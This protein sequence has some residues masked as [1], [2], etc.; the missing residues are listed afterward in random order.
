MNSLLTKVRGLA[1]DSAN[2]GV[3][4]ASALAANQAEITNSIAT[5]NNIANTTKFGASKYLLNGQAGVTAAVTGAEQRQS[6]RTEG[7]CCFGC[8]CPHESH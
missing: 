1:L 8:R 7:R 4:D 2:S 6:R 5:I 3:N